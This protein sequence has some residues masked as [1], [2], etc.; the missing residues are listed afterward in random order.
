[1][2]L[3]ASR[4]REIFFDSLFTDEEIKGQGQ[5]AVM[6]RAIV[7][8]GITHKI[9]FNPERLEPHRA[10]MI[11]MLAELPD[12]FHAKKGGGMSFLN[13]CERNDGQQW[14]DLHQTM[15]QLFCLAFGLGLAQPLLPRE[16][17]G[18]LPGGMPYIVVNLPD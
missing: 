5:A 8:E 14:A 4:V 7:V 13:A 1:M 16:A 6:A 9:G 11:E 3:T 17:W 2:K 10:E 12:A 15:D 18:V